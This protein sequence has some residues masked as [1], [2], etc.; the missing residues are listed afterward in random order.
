SKFKCSKRFQVFYQIGYGLGYYWFLVIW[1][2]FRISYLGFP[3]CFAA[4]A[5]FSQHCLQKGLVP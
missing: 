3:F 1:N 4:S 2:L 5:T